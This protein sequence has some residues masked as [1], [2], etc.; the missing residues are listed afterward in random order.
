MTPAGP[1]D[2]VDA[3]VWHQS[4]CLLY[5]NAL[6][7]Q[8]VLVTVAT[9]LAVGNIVFGAAL[10]PALVWTGA[11][12]LLGAGRA[13]LVRRFYARA[14]GVERTDLWFRRYMVGAVLAGIGW[15]LGAA[16]FMIDAGYDARFFTA[17][18]ISATIAGAVSTLA[19]SRGAL[20]IYVML[21]VLP[22]GLICAFDYGGPPD[23]ILIVLSLVFIAAVINSANNLRAILVEAIQLS[24]E[25]SRM[26]AE[27]QVSRD[28]AEIANRTKSQFLANMS[29]EIRTPMNGIIGLTELALM[30]PRA[31]DVPEHLQM[32]QASADSLLRILNDI[33]DFSKI[34]AG[35]ID[36][37]SESFDLHDTLRL[38]TQVLAAPA[39]A[40]GLDLRLEIPPDLP[41]RV[42]GDALR[43]KQV[44]TNLI[45]NAIKFTP[46][47]EV[48]VSA[49]LSDA[50]EDDVV[51]GFSVRDTGIGI[52]ADAQTLV[53]DA[54]AQA[55]SSTSRRYGG[56]GLGLTI[57]RRLV[58][59]MGGTLGVDSQPGRGS[60]FFF[61]V[62]FR[63]PVA[64][65]E[66]PIRSTGPVSQAG[67]LPQAGSAG[68]I[69]LV[70]DNPIN[71]KL[72]VALLSRKGYAVI[73]ADNG[74]KAV[75]RCAQQDFDLVLMDLQMP[76][77]DGL[78]ATRRIRAHEGENGRRHVP[79]VAMTASARDEDRQIC[80][81]AGM[82]DFLTKPLNVAQLFDRIAVVLQ[83]APR[84]D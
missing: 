55:D 23:L 34:E 10:L 82:D 13:M 39:Q 58:E 3:A 36:I 64:P 76:V 7:A 29:H 57:S 18:L 62:R 15:G 81:A 37:E 71:Q 11:M 78:E 79:I 32:I 84:S 43:L 40:K 9:L 19:P 27:L 56:T 24:L 12:V 41:R 2:R 75:E 45:G 35:R 1:T 77:M 46:H 80:F 14:P 25:R 16:L 38:S 69:L 49:S 31:P 17:G 20:T 30:D 28:Q 74:L 72:A 63:R 26:I 4:V 83:A 53:F 59:L 67:D 8:G 22:I 73:V 65:A 48:V 51:I 54:F 50:T 42:V 66:T 68:T 33:L 6:P 47:G 52:E 5:R 70:E 60:H 61:S 44:L 21:S